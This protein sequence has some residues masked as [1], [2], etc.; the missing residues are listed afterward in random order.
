MESV[1]T[2]EL[3]DNQLTGEIPSEIG[4][5]QT[6]EKLDL[7]A[8]QLSGQIPDNICNLNLDFSN[9]SEFR[10]DYNRLCPPYPSCIADYV[11]H[12]EIGDCD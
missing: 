11:G 10:V 6:L 7:F 3:N 2:I 5:L 1:Y 12:Q 8:N 4:D 9:G